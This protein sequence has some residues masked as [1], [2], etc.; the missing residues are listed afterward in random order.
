MASSVFSAS[1]FLEHLRVEYESLCRMLLPN[2]QYG[3]SDG[4]HRERCNFGG[5]LCFLFEEV[6]LRPW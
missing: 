4:G 1:P 3:N 5:E 6:A 2:S